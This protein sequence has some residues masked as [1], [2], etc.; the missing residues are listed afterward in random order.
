MAKGYENIDEEKKNKTGNDGTN[1]NNNNN[2]IMVYNFFHK[3]T[4]AT[5]KNITII[6][7]FDFFI[8]SFKLKPA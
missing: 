3:T 2:T 6:Y 5:R 1:N 4:D 7:P 8:F